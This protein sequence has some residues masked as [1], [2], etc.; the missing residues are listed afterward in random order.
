VN[1]CIDDHLARKPT[2]MKGTLDAGIRG[3]LLSRLYQGL[4]TFVRLE[5][6]A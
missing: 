2:L 3:T 5:E 4:P 1:D 6:A